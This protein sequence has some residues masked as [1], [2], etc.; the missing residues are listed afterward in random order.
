V[1]AVQRPLFHSLRAATAAACAVLVAS[2]GS[3]SSSPVIVPIDAHTR[4][5]LA[6]VC[7]ATEPSVNDFRGYAA[8]L[9]R[10]KASDLK[11]Y[12][13]NVGELLT[14][15]TTHAEHAVIGL[16]QAGAP[17][18]KHGAAF[19]RA[20]LAQ[21]SAFHSALARGLAWAK[22]IS[23]VN[24]YQFGLA[25]G[26]LQALLG[27]GL[28]AA[29]NAVK[30]FAAELHSPSVAAAKRTIPACRTGSVQP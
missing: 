28:G 2:C 1:A 17:D 25:F 12:K 16:R 7:A 13:R 29:G 24:G 3:N 30:P 11:T 4:A 27:Q 22:G 9:A 15:M 21:Y 8:A 18:F 10:T 26:G 23:T 14:T 19:A 20:V 6:S 5:Y